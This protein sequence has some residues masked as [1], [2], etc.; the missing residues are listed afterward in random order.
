MLAL[1]F[2]RLE[3]NSVLIVK[4]LS[5]G[6]LFIKTLV[7]PDPEDNIIPYLSLVGVD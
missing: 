1:M 4:L 5:Q 6:I 7:S 2:L 3:K